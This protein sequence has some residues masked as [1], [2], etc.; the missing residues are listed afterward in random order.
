MDKRT[1]DAYIEI[2]RQELV[3]ALGCT[4]PIAIAFGAARARDVLGC[5]PDN[6]WVCCSGNIIKN[7][8][9]V[10]VPNSGGLK[11]IAAAAVLGCTG[12]DWTRGLEVLNS[13]EDSHREQTKELLK[14]DF[15]GCSLKEDAPNLYIQVTA[16]KRNCRASVTIED[17]H[18]NITEICKD[19]EILFQ[20]DRVRNQESENSRSLLNLKD[21]VEFA[22]TVDLKEVR[23]IIKRQIDYNLAISE[24]GLAHG[25][26]CQVGRTILDTCSK[27]ELG[28]IAKARAA[29]GSDARMSGCSLPVVINSG[30]GNQGMTAS[31]PV[32]EYAKGLN[33]EE[34]KLYR[35]LCISNL[36]AQEQK[37][38]IGSLSAYCG[39][40]CAAAGAGAAI[41]YLCG[42]TLEQIGSTVT[43]TICNI[44]GMVCDGAK[45]S[46]AAKIASTVDAAVMAHNMSMKARSF[47]NGDGLMQES[48]E[49]TIQ[50]MGY[51]G[52]IGMKQTDVEILNLMLGNTEMEKEPSA[53]LNRSFN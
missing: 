30:S 16:Q 1:Y 17:Y 25:W 9:S 11:G 45:P 28:V 5:F 42:G 39:A 52:R 24:E 32:I 53:L 13:I 43:N 10:K 49:T 27:Q 37:K 34:E 7:A 14:Q 29:A 18:T 38:W 19:G 15:C 23:E 2:L 33:V 51:V 6:I 40:V 44:G 46:C 8:K 48:A 50:A 4:E 41:T 22:E 35:A 20:K 26:G 3:P 47:A 31:L 36:L 21:I 12:G